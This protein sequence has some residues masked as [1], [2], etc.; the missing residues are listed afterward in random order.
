[1][2]IDTRFTKCVEAKS[3][4]TAE[5]R[6]HPNGSIDLEHYVRVGREA[7]GASVRG[8]ARRLTVMLRQFIGHL[9]PKRS[10]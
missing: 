5:I 10:R 2:F 6:R 4:A 1:M 9:S 3:L 8:S 7:H